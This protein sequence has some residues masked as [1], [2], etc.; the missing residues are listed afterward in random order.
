MKKRLSAILALALMMVAMTASVAFAGEGTLTLE[1]TYPRDGDTGM[2]IENSG[3]KLYFDQNMINKKNEKANLDCFKF[4]DAKGRA[5]PIRVLYSPKEEGLVL[6]LV[7]NQT[8]ESN[9][10]Y[11]LYVSGDVKAASGDTLGEDLTIEFTTVDTG[12]ATTINMV[13][14]FVMMGAVMVASSKAA[15]QQQKNQNAEKEVEEKF[16]PYK[17]AKETGKSVAEVLRE[18]EANREK[19]KKK[20]E[21]KKA[22]EAALLAEIEAEEEDDYEEVIESDNKK[23]KGPRPA[24]AAGSKYVEQLKAKKAEEAKRKAAAGTTNPKNKCKK[25]KK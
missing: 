20:I 8:L 2:Q 25:K 12:K 14:T 10:D 13:L 21:K 6:V 23:V 3:V 18:E 9:S 11:K 19:Q 16:N 24:S 5:L 17:V 1:D 7:D 22:K 4:T 15:K